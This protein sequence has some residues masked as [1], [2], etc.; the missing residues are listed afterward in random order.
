MD[1]WRPF[2]RQ[3]VHMRQFV[4]AVLAGLLWLPVAH[5]GPDRDVS[6]HAASKESQAAA[7]EGSEAQADRHP[8][9]EGKGGEPCNCSRDR[10]SRGEMEIGELNAARSR[11]ELAAEE[12]DV[13]AAKAAY[14]EAQRHAA[15]VLELYP[16]VDKVM[17]DQ[18]LERAHQ[19]YKDAKSKH[20]DSGPATP[21][22]DR[23]GAKG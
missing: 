13:D 8:A 19:A 23:H 15:E 18:E 5:A 17:V 10:Q 7:G 22:Q 11:A 6:V 4:L 21:P 3:E 20:G 12:G 2:A 14:E 9:G 16:E 1:G